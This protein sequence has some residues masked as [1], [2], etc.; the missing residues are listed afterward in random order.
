VSR[1][2]R[3][4]RSRRAGFTLA[5]PGGSAA[6]ALLPGLAEAAVD[7][8]R[9]DVFWCDERGVPPHHP[10]S[11]YGLAR[12]LLLERVALQPERIH[13]MCADAEA[14]GKAAAE[15]DAELRRVCGAPPALDLALVGVGPDG[16]I[17]SLFPG[18]RALEEKVRL[19]VQVAGAP[20]PPARRLTLT[21]PALA[22][23][24]QLVASAFGSAKADVA[25]RM[26]SEPA[27]PLPAARAL[28]AAAR[29]V[30]LL[31][32]PAAARLPRV[33]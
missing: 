31:D 3:R 12:R 2:R 24:R 18:H 4:R 16:H 21:L 26:L 14:I 20:K 32:P 23:A 33:Q 9:V 10:D 29:A 27:S 11:N 13:R 17:C 6:E 30:V 15:Y 22:G 8:S 5:I 1:R 28:R 19:V 7:W 25:R